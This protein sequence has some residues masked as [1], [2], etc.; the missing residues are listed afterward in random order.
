MQITIRA[1]ENN[2]RT[3]NIAIL[4]GLRVEIIDAPELIGSEKQVAWAADI[5]EQSIALLAKKALAALI[6]GN[7]V[8]YDA[9]E[10]DAAIARINN[11]MMTQ[12]AD[13]LQDATLAK[14]WIENRHMSAPSLFQAVIKHGAV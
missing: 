8:T 7:G 5:R 14:A 9:D 4:N 13:M 10:L 3:D 6:K 1:I 2:S 11:E 12:L